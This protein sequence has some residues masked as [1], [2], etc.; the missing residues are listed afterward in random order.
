MLILHNVKYTVLRILQT[1]VSRGILN[2][3]VKPTFLAE[4]ENG[5]VP[6][7]DPGTESGSIVQ[8]RTKKNAG[9]KFQ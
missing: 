7:M 5:K 2:T 3:T 8:H 1:N 4:K 9:N 6:L